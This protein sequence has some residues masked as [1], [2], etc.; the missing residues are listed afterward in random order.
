L[1]AWV[2]CGGHFVLA[3]ACESV[4]V[5]LLRLQ[6]VVALVGEAGALGWLMTL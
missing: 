1:E 6:V 2:C 4:V 3:V 5:V